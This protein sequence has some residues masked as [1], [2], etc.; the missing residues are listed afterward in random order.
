MLI[1]AHQ[2]LFL[3]AAKTGGNSV[4]SLLVNLSDDRLTANPN[5][6]G[7]DRFG[8]IGA[9]TPSKHAT[10]AEYHVRMGDKIWDFAIAIGIRDP[11]DRA[12][13]YYFSPHHQRRPPAPFDF[14][15]FTASL[16]GLPPVASILTVDGAVREPAFWLRYGHLSDDWMALCEAL[17]LKLGPL[18][19]R[20]AGPSDPMKAEI[21]A[22]RR[23]RSLI[24]SQYSQDYSLL[25]STGG[26]IG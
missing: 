11:L 9:I 4:Q 25:E 24:A 20:N 6:D 3:H 12:I 18:P 16:S 15:H 26:S 19:R 22:D 17:D 7:V 14:D 2:L 8:V 21:A 10:L 5:Q 13:S 23:V 1:S